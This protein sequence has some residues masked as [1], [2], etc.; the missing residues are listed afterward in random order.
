MVEKIP[1]ELP[2]S[3]EPKE[4]NLLKILHDYPQVIQIAAENLSPAMIANYVY[5]L[6]KEYN[7]F[8]HQHQILREE[9]SSVRNFR[10]QLSEFVAN[11]IKSAT[12]L[13]G[14]EVPERM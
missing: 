10:I 1:G 6:A 3:I 7:Q 2:Q 12:G 5:D 11:T 14:I 9:D 4:K 13:L 8:Y